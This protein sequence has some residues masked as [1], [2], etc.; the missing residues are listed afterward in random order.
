[1]AIVETRL[2]PSILR[3]YDIRGII[4]KTLTSEVAD[5]IGRCFGTMAVARGTSEVGV[6]YDGRLSS[7]ELEQALVAGLAACGLTVVRF[8]RGPT[9]MLYFGLQ[10]RDISA[11]VMVTGSH[12]PPDYNGFKLLIDRTPLTAEEIRALGRIAQ[13]GA[14]AAGH[15][16]VRD[17]DVRDAYG[18]R[19]A[20]GYR[21][22]RELTIAW[23][24]GNGAAGDVIPQLCEHLPGLRHVLVNEEV[25]GTFPAHHPDPA[26]PANL[27]QLQDTVTQVGCDLGIAFDG[28]GDRIGVVDDDGEI[29]WPDQVLLLLA[30]DV[31]RER[32]GATI[33]A[34]VKSSQTLFDG[35]EAAG[36]RWVMSPSG[37][38]VTR[39]TMRE[40]GAPL[41]GE[42]S[43]HVFFADRFYGAD[44]ALYCAMRVLSIAAQARQP[45]AAF[46]RALP[47]TISTPELRI[48]CP[49]HRK[50]QVVAAVAERLRAAGADMLEIDGVRVRRND[51]WWML[52]AS[53]TEPAL[54]ARCEAVDAGI[55]ERLKEELAAELAAGGV[56]VPDALGRPVSAGDLGRGGEQR[57][58]ALPGLIDRP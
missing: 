54:A 41:A 55:F 23:D 19:L 18:E 44:D 4:G 43:G 27:A 32:P 2:D 25:D 14:F 17:V 10:H 40:R 45:L 11:G 46:R 21:R 29:L 42:M 5:L 36:G 3:E 34:D 49:E 26:I 22:G 52:R 16:E 15:G 13:E 38:P 12:N 58:E 7:P 35:V 37:Y 9:P 48:R 50:R 56:P 31:L 47:K 8:G 6:G 33:V 20:E 39:R 30:R 57:N 53:N 28:D 24:L 51:G 1:M